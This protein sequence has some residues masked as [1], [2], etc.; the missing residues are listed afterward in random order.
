MVIIEITLELVK[1]ELIKFYKENNRFP[2][3]YE[4][5]RNYNIFSFSYNKMMQLFAQNNESVQ[6]Y[7]ASIDCFALTKPNDKY[8][9]VYL[10]KLKDLI[11]KDGS[12]IGYNLY[13]FDRH[14][15]SNL[16][17]MRWFIKHCPDK[18]V[19]NI[20]SFKEWSGISK[21]FM[22]KDEC[23]EIIKKMAKAY[24]RPLKYDDFRKS[25]Y[26]NVNIEMIKRYWGS[27]NAMKKSLGLEI[28]QPK[29][30]R[31]TQNDLEKD[32]Y[33]VQEY[34]KSSRKDYIST[35]EWDLIKEIHHTCA[36]RKFIKE[37]HNMSLK[38]YLLMYGIKIGKQGI[39]LRYTFTDGEITTSQFE[40]LLSSYLRSQ[41]FQFNKNYTRNIKYNKIDY[42]YNGMMDC[43][44]KVKINNIDVYIEMAGIIANYKQW[45][46]AG[47]EIISSKTKDKYRLK[48]AEKEKML[49]KTGVMYFILFPCDLLTD[50]FRKIFINPT[51]D[52]RLEIENYNQH[53]INWALVNKETIEQK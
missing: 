47:R 53:N 18:S 6:D 2:K 13:E 36:I 5:K 34:L 9:D 22:P 30:E 1:F 4:F 42:E 14:G 21:R 44:Y 39:G 40:Y 17:G 31:I 16:P 23:E 20:D 10:N 15:G 11:C 33:F 25:G 49:K 41:G 32:I 38:E 19:N 35:S 12:N 7:M 29:M 26:Q 48:L 45:Y 43:D 37:N 46:Y 52:L 24:N 27:V 28:I 51:N 8:Y 50:S 3:S